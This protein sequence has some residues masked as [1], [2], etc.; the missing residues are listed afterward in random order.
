MSM[1]DFC[2]LKRNVKK[3]NVKVFNPIH[4]PIVEM[5]KPTPREIKLCVQHHTD[6]K[7]KGQEPN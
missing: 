5:R 1:R 2:N 3:K 6:I 4:L 7:V